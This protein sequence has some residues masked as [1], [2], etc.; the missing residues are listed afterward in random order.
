[1]KRASKKG[2]TLI[3]MLLAIAITMIISGLFISLIVSIRSSYYRS[4]NDVDCSDIGIFYSS[5]KNGP[6]IPQIRLC[7]YRKLN[8][9]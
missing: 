6:D 9:N 1:M 5:K 7:D 3:E 2:F 8:L 4:Y